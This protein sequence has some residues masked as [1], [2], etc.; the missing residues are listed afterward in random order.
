MQAAGLGDVYSTGKQVLYDTFLMSLPFYYHIC[1]LK[2]K[3]K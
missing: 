2:M 3:R 1:D